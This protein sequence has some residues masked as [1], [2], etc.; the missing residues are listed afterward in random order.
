MSNEEYQLLSVDEAR[1]IP[2]AMILVLTNGRP[3][4]VYEVDI[5]GFELPINDHIITEAAFT[6]A[7]EVR[8]KTLSLG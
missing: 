3:S 5:Y 4:A 7:S 6:K 1:D 2:R 8:H